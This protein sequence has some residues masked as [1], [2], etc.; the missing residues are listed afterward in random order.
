MVKRK[1]P[2]LEVRSLTLRLEPGVV[3]VGL[4]VVVV[5]VAVAVYPHLLVTGK[6]S[7]K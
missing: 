1:A 4:V 5:A 6:C 7:G 3:V 2:A